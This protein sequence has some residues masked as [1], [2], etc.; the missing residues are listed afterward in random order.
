MG[1]CGVRKTLITMQSQLRAALRRLRLKVESLEIFPRASNPEAIR[2]LADEWN[3]L[4]RCGSIVSDEERVSAAYQEDFF[5]VLSCVWGI[6]S[7][8]LQRGDVARSLELLIGVNRC[9]QLMRACKD[10]RSSVWKLQ[11][12]RC[13][14]ACSGKPQ[15][16]WRSRI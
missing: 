8:E 12:L 5:G 14:L 11:V 6:I 13:A 3:R 7:D 4:E 9:M 1:R 2:L 15:Q 10:R 16:I